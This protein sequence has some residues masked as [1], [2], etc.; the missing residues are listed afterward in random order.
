MLL[1]WKKTSCRRRRKLTQLNLNKPNL[2]LTSPN[3]TLLHLEVLE[4]PA[5]NDLGWN[6]GQVV[7]VTLVAV[8]ELGVG[9]DLGGAE[10][11]PD[12]LR[13]IVALVVL[14]VQPLLSHNLKDILSR[15]F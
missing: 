6:D 1:W 4:I 15:M 9:A 10:Q 2:T 14:R 3:L 5:V 11:G 13:A 8:V 12:G 7:G